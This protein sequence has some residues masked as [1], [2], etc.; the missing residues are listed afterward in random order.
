MDRYKY[1]DCKDI[2]GR[3]MQFGKNKSIP[4]HC[5][6][7]FV[8][9]YSKEFIKSIIDEQKKR[10]EYCLDP[11]SGSGT[12]SLEL[13]QIGIKCVSFEVNPFMYN[14]SK[15][16]INSPKYDISAIIQHVELMKS[17]TLQFSD[18]EV[19]FNSPFKT[20]TENENVKKWN[21]NKSVYIAIEKI[22]LAIEQIEDEIYRNLYVTALASLLPEI[23]NMYRNG[24]CLSYKKNWKDISYK[25]NEIFDKFLDV[26]LNT[27][28]PDLKNIVFNRSIDNEIYLHHGDCNRLSRTEIEDDSIDLVITSPPYL[29]SRDYTDSYM[30]ELRALGYVRNHQEIRTLRDN[31][32]KSHVQV[33][34]NNVNISNV[35]VQETIDRIN[36][37]SLKFKTWNKQIPNMIAAY[38]NDIESLLASLYIKMKKGGK[39][40]FNVSN[41]AY[42]NVLINTLDIVANIAEENGFNVQEIREA[43][44]LKSSPQQKKEIKNLL[45]GVIVL[46]K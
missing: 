45:E 19:Q 39:V 38:F 11:F 3:I 30:L 16:K 5:W 12:T 29:N 28:I 22:K 24:K 14:L 13:Q 46:K 8:E 18:D 37:K 21:I 2:Y 23:S 15:S 25:Q 42:Y 44:Y 26:I 43:R 1:V 40:Y 33:K 32:L 20:L 27:F 6:Y 31:T 35:Y 36:E 7:P 34:Y 9:G 17:Y 10:P 41:S 4:I